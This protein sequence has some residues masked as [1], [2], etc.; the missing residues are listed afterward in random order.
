MEHEPHLPDIEDIGV[1]I[2]QFETDLFLFATVAS[3]IASD[4]DRILGKTVAEIG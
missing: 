3:V 4:P 2:E 1:T